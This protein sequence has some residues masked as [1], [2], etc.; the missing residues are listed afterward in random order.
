MWKNQKVGQLP[1]EEILRIK[2]VF[3]KIDVFNKIG[4][5]LIDGLEGHILLTGDE[6]YPSRIQLSND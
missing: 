6:V 3:N 1:S 5:Q 4:K 2:Y